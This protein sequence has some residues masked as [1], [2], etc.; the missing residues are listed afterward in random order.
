METSYLHGLD[1]VELA[2]KFTLFFKTTTKRRTTVVN[3]QTQDARE[4]F[5]KKIFTDKCVA[6]V[7]GQQRS[8]NGLAKDRAPSRGRD[9]KPS[10]TTGS[11]PRGFT[12]PWTRPPEFWHS[13]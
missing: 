1:N 12:G 10:G 13:I 5:K 11:L 7:S 8:H 9:P 4:C 3:I 6:R 2:I